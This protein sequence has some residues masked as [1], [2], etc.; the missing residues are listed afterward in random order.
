VATLAAALA[1]GCDP[2]VTVTDDDVIQQL[3]ASPSPLVADGMA[4]TEVTVGTVTSDVAP[5]LQV[6]L[7]IDGA[8]WVGSAAATIT[9]PLGPDGTAS[10]LVVAPRTAGSARVTAELAGYQR[11]LAI[12]L[13]AATPGDIVLSSSG[14]L[15]AGEPSQLQV[16]AQPTIATGGLPTAQTAIR[17]HLDAEPVGSAY[18]TADRVVLDATATTAATTVVA[19]TKT[20]SVTVTADATPP[21][22]PAPTATSSALV[23]MLL[24]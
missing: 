10:A 2:S 24:P 3:A 8:A 15:V 13:I 6:S 9:K 14:A 21:G 12:Q 17:F 19:G 18:L 4:V 16:T 5:D 20:T 7:T 1:A 22:A 11:D 23:V